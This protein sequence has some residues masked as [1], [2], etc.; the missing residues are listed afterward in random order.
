MKKL[1]LVF[2]SS[3]FLISSAFAEGQVTAQ[4]I[5]TALTARSSALQAQT[6]KLSAPKGAEI[7]EARASYDTYIVVINYSNYPIIAVFP[8]QGIVLNERTAA[9]YE[10]SNYM[11]STYIELRNINN[12]PFWSGFVQYHDILS[13]YVSNGQYVVY[14]TH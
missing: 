9:R 14:D 12:I 13:V 1:L 5:S 6:S 8:S 11:G 2:I 3:F 7:A 10:R 4:S